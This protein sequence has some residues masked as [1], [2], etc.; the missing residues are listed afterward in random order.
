MS[1]NFSDF[2]GRPE[3][4][5]DALSKFVS[6]RTYHRFQDDLGR[7]ETW[8]EV[9]VRA[10]TFLFKTA[11]LT[12]E[13]KRDIFLALYDHEALC[14]MR[15]LWAAGPA[16]EANNITVFN[17]S[18]HYIEDLQ[19]FAETL[20][21]LMCGTGVGASV[22][23]DAVENLP[24]IVKPRNNVKPDV[25]KID[26]S[27]EGWADALRVGL[28]RWFSGHDIIYD[29]TGLRPAGAR[30][31]TMGGR[32]SG[33]EPLRRLLNFTRQR[34]LAR[35]GR[36][37][38][39]I[40]VGDITNM[41]GECVVAGGVRRSSE[42][43]KFSADDQLMLRAKSGAWYNQ[44]PYRA[45]ANN[46][47]G[48]DEKP[49]P[50]EFMRTWQT[51]AESGS[52]EPGIFNAQNVLLTSPRRKRWGG[53]WGTNP[54]GEINL[55]NRQFCNLSECVARPHDTLDSLIHKVRIATIVGTIQS[56]MTNF[57]YLRPEWK[58]NSDEERLLGVSI[59]GQADCP[60]LQ[61]PAVLAELRHTAI[62]TNEQYAKRFGITQ[63]AA[64]TC[65]KPSG[66]TS[67]KVSSSSGIHLR[68]S[69]YYIRRVRISATDP[70]FTFMR[71]YGVPAEP[72]VG[73]DPSTAST[74]VLSFPVQSPEG[75]LTLKD[76]TAL[77]QLDVE[78]RQAELHRT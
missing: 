70:L 5:Q 64:V 76:A 27:R 9:C 53:G 75:A 77:D 68:R 45:M 49:D 59:T 16:A 60:I 61:D 78:A 18:F 4:F 65:V 29:Y 24:R 28:H 35:A 71:T 12:P 23:Y 72:E 33:P 51:L 1:F 48:Y 62:A 74:W 42:I 52:G 54:C 19:S 39:T 50:V 58:K 6:Y 40:D 43:L 26:D 20:Y 22:E 57:T 73:Q 25:Y 55:R 38:Q 46:S 13:E 30:L 47:I 14:S 63:S 44:H 41:T 66:T 32:S 69:P 7:R 10:C 31:M 8:F 36:R 17:C 34:V 15:L 2:E 56:M 21:I 11:P 67:Q 37:L 3:P